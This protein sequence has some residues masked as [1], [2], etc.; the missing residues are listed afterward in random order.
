MGW[1]QSDAVGEPLRRGDRVKV[2]RYSDGWGHI[3]IGDYVG[4]VAEVRNIECPEYDLILQIYLFLDDGE[5]GWA[6]QSLVMKV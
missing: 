5:A 2:F 1:N 6:H 4:Q 3:I